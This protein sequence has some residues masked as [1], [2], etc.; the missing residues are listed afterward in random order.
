MNLNQIAKYL[1]K[2][3]TDEEMQVMINHL[4]TL[5]A[6][7][8]KEAELNQLGIKLEKEGKTGEPI[9]IY[10]SLLDDNFEGSHPYDRLAIIYR[11]QKKKDEVIRVL[12]KAIYVF[13]NI[14]NKDQG[15][16]SPKLEKYKKELEKAKKA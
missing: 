3:Y 5:N 9:A 1:E 12:E 13:E 14:V 11:K 10:E 8:M 15:D 6:Q 7:H 2:N 16:R 4:E